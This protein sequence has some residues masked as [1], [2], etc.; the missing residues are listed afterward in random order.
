[1]SATLHLPILELNGLQSPP[2]RRS[3]G[4]AL[5]GLFGHE[6]IDQRLK[7]VQRLLELGQRRREVLH[8]Q[9]RQ[10][11][12]HVG[13]LAREHFVEHHPHG[14]EIALD[15][16]WGTVDLLGTHVARTAQKG[17]R[18]GHDGAIDP[19]GDAKI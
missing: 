3:I 7:Q 6:A 4:K 15:T 16:G 11:I 2:H 9:S 19:L 17:V 8:G 10:G 18:R 13:H 5:F 1:M 12:G 14:V